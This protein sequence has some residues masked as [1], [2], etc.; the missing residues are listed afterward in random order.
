M[1]SFYEIIR[2][3]F[4]VRCSP[5]DQYRNTDMI[6]FEGKTPKLATH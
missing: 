4:L 2:L 5:K 6:F 3:T 1:F